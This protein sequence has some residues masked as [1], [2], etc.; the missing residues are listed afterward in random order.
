[1]KGLRK[2]F[3]SFV[4]LSGALAA[5]LSGLWLTTDVKAQTLNTFN[6]IQYYYRTST[7]A[8]YTLNTVNNATLVHNFQQKAYG[9]IYRINASGILPTAIS[10]K[11]FSGSGVIHINIQHDTGYDGGFMCPNL[12]QLT[13]RPEQGTITS[14]QTQVEYCK[15]VRSTAANDFWDIKVASAGNLSAN[16][17]VSSFYIRLIGT[18]Q[19]PVFEFTSTPTAYTQLYMTADIN[20]TMSTDPN[21]AVLGEINQ[22]IT[23]INNYNEQQAQQDQEDRENISNTSEQA[24]EDGED[25]GEAAA[26]KGQT[27]LQAF[28]SLIAALNQVHATNCNLPNMQVYSLHLDNMNMCAVSLPT[29]VSALLGIGTS[30]LMVVLGINLVKRMIRLYKEITG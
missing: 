29:G 8:S 26:D 18:E 3:Y 30:V 11:S 4:I 15:K 9:A 10:G 2:C 24:Q 27:L 17:T 20:F 23:N 13:I 14:E 25:A 7:N 6:S 16:T 12:V 21:T 28:G 22:N 19:K 5:V 1:M